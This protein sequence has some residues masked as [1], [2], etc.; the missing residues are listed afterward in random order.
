[1]RLFEILIIFIGLAIIEYWHCTRRYR[2]INQLRKVRDSNATTD[3]G[4][5]NGISYAIE[6]IEKL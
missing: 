5:K 1:M 3:D 2:L 6:Q 4:F